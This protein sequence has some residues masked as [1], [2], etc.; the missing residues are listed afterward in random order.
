MA[1]LFAG[2]DTLCKLHGSLGLS[3]KR[4]ALVEFGS[5]PICPLC[6]RA[7]RQDE[8]AAWAAFTGFYYTRLA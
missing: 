1:H 2:R 3:T 8:G 4:Y 6:A 7:A 5:L